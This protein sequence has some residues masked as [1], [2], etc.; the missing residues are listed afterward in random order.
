MNWSDHRP[1]EDYEYPE[2]DEDDDV[3]ETVEC[4]ECGADVFEDADVCPQCY[5]A[6]HASKSLWQGRPIWWILLGLIGI[7]ATILALLPR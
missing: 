5:A 6:I 4:P 7:A 2:P 3:Y 1:I